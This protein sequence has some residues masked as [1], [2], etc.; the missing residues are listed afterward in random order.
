MCLKRRWLDSISSINH[1]NYK[2]REVKDLM[3]V[4]K[5]F[6]GKCDQKSNTSVKGHAET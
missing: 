2:R 1:K 4:P 6:E 5:A 3:L